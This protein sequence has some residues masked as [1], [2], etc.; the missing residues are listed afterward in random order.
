M[1]ILRQIA[2]PNVGGKRL[3]IPGKKK[4]HAPLLYFPRWIE[5][6]MSLKPRLKNEYHACIYDKAKYD[7]W[8]EKA[9]VVQEAWAYNVFCN[10]GLDVIR[11]ESWTS[12][13][14][15]FGRVPHQ[16]LEHC[17]V[18][19]GAGVPAITDTSFFTYLSSADMATAG[20]VANN[21]TNSFNHATDEYYHRHKFFWDLEEGNGTLTEVGLC[22]QD[23]DLDNVIS[24]AMFQDAEGA[25]ISIVKDNTK[26]MVVTVTLYLERGTTDSG[27]MLLDDGIEGMIDSDYALSTTNLGF[28]LVMKDHYIPASGFWKKAYLYLGSTDQAV[29][30]ADCYETS[31]PVLGSTRSS[32]LVDSAVA[33]GAGYGM[34]V[35][36]DWDLGEGN[37]TWYE[38]G[39]RTGIDKFEKNLARWDLP[40]TG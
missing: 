15:E 11:R 9:P 32:K 34:T 36:A 5:R 6:G 12:I 33:S 37:D 14:F 18:G 29:A 2:S 8:G 16:I 27:A 17:G 22:Y 10:Q 13:V 24:H 40:N 20:E 26:V 21:D 4:I 28:G 39:F 30:Q 38:V 1:K 35:Y 23:G 19:T 3:I 31:Y 7:K 25:P